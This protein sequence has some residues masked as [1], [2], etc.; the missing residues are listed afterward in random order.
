MG[1]GD[2]ITALLEYDGKSISIL[3]EARTKYRQNANFI[4]DL[5]ALLTGPDSNLSD[6]ASWIL[7]ME[8]EEGV[9]LSSDQ[10][11]LLMSSLNGIVSWQAILHILQL[12]SYLKLTDLQ[13]KEMIEWAE[14]FTQQKKPFLRA[15][16]YHTIIIWGRQYPAFTRKAEKALE[17]ALVDP[18]ASVRARARQLS[19]SPQ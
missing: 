10:T 17:K 6:G 14:N 4:E 2:L 5:I 11:D 7:K 3:S 1:S 19:P 8:L 15:W 12:T 9:P 16:S 13:A 18:A